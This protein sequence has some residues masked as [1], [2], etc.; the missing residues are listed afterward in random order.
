MYRFLF[1]PK[2]IAFHL[3]VA[4]AIV[5]MINLGF[6]Q[7]RRLDERQ[8][9]NSA[10]AERE[11]EPAVP[12]ADLLGE[13]NFDPDTAEWRR[14]TAE[15]TWLPGQLLVF[16]RSQNGIAGENVLTALTLDDGTTVIVNRGFV[17]LA[18][19]VPEPPT[20]EAAILATVRE[21][22]SGGGEVVDP[23]TGELAEVQRVDVGRL[24]PQFDGDVAPVYLDLIASEPA[25]TPA[26]P[27]PVPPPEQSEGNHLSYA[28]Q[29]FIFSLCV[30]I[31]WV[32]AVRHSIGKRRTEASATSAA[33][34]GGPAASEST[35]P[36]EPVAP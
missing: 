27:L 6:W 34:P 31:G 1:R 22:Q 23:D 21:S 25:I 7:L 3:L 30:A 11:A 28:I 14:V 13:P 26:D 16:N 33:H 12:L 18:R 9:L 4:V 19:D 2:W 5:V 10:V 20:T 8:A 32:L 29:W 24:A 35:G 17:P 36:S 15:G